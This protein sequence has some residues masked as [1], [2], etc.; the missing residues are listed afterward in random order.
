LVLINRNN[1]FKQPGSQKGKLSRVQMYRETLI[2]FEQKIHQAKT[3]L[4]ATKIF[5]RNENYDEELISVTQSILYSS[6]ALL[7]AGLGYEMELLNIEKAIHLSQNFTT[8]LSDLFPCNSKEEQKIFAFL[9]QRETNWEALPDVLPV[10]IKRATE[11]EQSLHNYPYKNHTLLKYHS[12][13]SNPGNYKES[14]AGESNI[15]EKIFRDQPCRYNYYWKHFFRHYSKSQP[16]FLLQSL[17][18]PP[19]SIGRCIRR[20]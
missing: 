9:T 2:A 10:L 18:I 20:A 7:R 15:Q 14:V 17:L 4:E 11:L 16:M 3:G 5:L 13:N 6:T 8:L 12:E 19:F 1:S